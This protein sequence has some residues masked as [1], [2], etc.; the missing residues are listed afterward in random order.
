[1]TCL[2]SSR[3]PAPLDSDG[4]AMQ[5]LD[6]MRRL[7]LGVGRRTPARRRAGKRQPPPIDF[8]RSATSSARRRHGRGPKIVTVSLT[9]LC[10]CSRFLLYGHITFHYPILNSPFSLSLPLVI[11]ALA[12]QSDPVYASLLAPLVHHGPFRDFG[13]D[14]QPRAGPG[15]AGAA[16]RERAKH[17]SRPREDSPRGH[18]PRASHAR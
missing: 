8:R 5:T 2:Q 18:I 6:R 13:D 11:C 4:L 16:N 7:I 17:G 14:D 1:V 15:E 3:D 10:L 9:T 12:T